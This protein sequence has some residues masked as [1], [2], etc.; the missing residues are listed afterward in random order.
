ML[1]G[2]DNTVGASP[3][4]LQALVDAN[5]GVQPSYGNDAWTALAEQRIA[6]CFAHEVKV[7]FVGSGTVANSLA[8]SALVPPWGAVLAQADA[9]IVRDESTAPEL[10]TG[11]A[12]IQ[13][14]APHAG[15]LTAAA[16]QAGVGGAGHPPHHPLPGALSVTQINERGLV[17]TPAELQALTAAARQHGLRTHMDG[18]RFANAVAALQCHPADITWRAGVDVLSLGASKN[19]ALMAEAVVFFDPALAHD[20]AWRVKRAGQMAAKGR[21]FGAQ[22]VAWLADGH[23]LTLAAH[24]NAMAARLAQ[25]LA[26]ARHARLAWPAAANQVFA[27]LPAQLAQSL[28]ERGAQFYPWRGAWQ[29]GDPVL[30]SNEVL[31]RLVTSFA[32]T[33]E[34]IE[35]FLIHLS[36]E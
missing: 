3:R 24:A 35:Q 8:L 19:G 2:S 13:G 14:L 28:R 11:G 7:F 10:F 1:F 29:D 18:A 33:P 26:N 15:K 20:F 4:V 23:W 36:Q 30:D 27:I 32:T 9:H 5:A 22:F 21:F 25:G 17:Y 6:E 31:V 16:I 12:R 34:Q